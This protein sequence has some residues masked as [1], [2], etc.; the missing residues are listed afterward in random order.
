M[1]A[2]VWSNLN[3]FTHGGAIQVKARNSRDE[4]ISNFKPHHVSGLL[5]SSA[6]LSL[7]AGVAIASLAS[8]DVLANELRN[9]Y[10]AVY[11]SEA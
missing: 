10:R 2:Q 1:K 5:G 7:L 9:A 11:E 6:T 3:D 4:I 8:A